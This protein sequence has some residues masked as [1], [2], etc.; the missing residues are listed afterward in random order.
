MSKCID[1]VGNS[2]GCESLNLPLM[3]WCTLLWQNTLGKGGGGGVFWD[4]K[5]NGLIPTAS[6]HL[7]G[8]RARARKE[9]QLTIYN[10]RCRIA[11]ID[12]MPSYVNCVV[13]A[14]LN[15]KGHCKWGLF[16]NKD[17]QGRNVY[18]DIGTRD[19]RIDRCIYSVAAQQQN[20]I[21]IHVVS[22]DAI[23][24]GVIC[25]TNQSINQGESV[26][27]TFFTTVIAV[28]YKCSFMVSQTTHLSLCLWDLEHKLK[29]VKCVQWLVR[30][31]WQ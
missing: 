4:N 21:D 15:R 10:V 25:C 30:V 29:G 6:I 14:C 28:T 2:A 18:V 19:D 13:L 24:A 8:C 9:G 7:N 17:F 12:E 3:Q 1:W 26:G 16:S 23:A 5:K 31:L 27:S 20:C 22:S 11:S